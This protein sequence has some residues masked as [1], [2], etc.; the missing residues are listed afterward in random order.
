MG[1]GGSVVQD[2]SRAERETLARFQRDLAEGVRRQLCWCFLFGFGPARRG[3]LVCGPH[4]SVSVGS[5]QSQSCLPSKMKRSVGAPA[6]EGG[7]TLGLLG[8]SASV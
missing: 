7:Q 1:V 5:S 6:E 2:V 4:V 8:G 3:E